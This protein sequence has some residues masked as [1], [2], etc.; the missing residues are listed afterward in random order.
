MKNAIE[1][2]NLTYRDSC[3][4]LLIES[5]ACGTPVIADRESGIWE[6]IKGAQGH[7]V[8]ISL[9][10]KDNKFPIKNPHEVIFAMNYYKSASYDIEF[11]TC[12]KISNVA[13]KY[14]KFFEELL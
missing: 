8:D 1:V 11:P 5:L 3:P 4:N 7:Q 6:Y 2:I 13:D 14:I 12:L 10:E 9:P